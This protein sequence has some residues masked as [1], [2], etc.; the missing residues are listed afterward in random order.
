MDKTTFMSTFDQAAAFCREFARRYVIEALPDSLRFDFAA[1]NRPPDEQGRILFL[2]GRLLA[3]EQLRKVEPIRARKYLWVDGKVPLWINFNVHD[4]DDT[5]T[6]VSVGVSY[7]LTSNDSLLYHREEGLPPFHI[8]GPSVPPDWVSLEAS[9]RF[10]LHWR[11]KV[12]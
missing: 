2:G 10:S 11:S 1:S 8:L 6:Y 4:A 12:V 5:H 9:G 7:R 3:P